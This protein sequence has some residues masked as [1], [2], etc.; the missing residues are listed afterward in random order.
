M[1]GSQK[2]INGSQKIMLSMRKVAKKSW[3]SQV[4]PKGIQ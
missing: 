4:T 1:K 2:I 3:N